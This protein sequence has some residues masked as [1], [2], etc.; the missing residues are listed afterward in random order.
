MEEKSRVGMK[1]EETLRVEVVEMALPGGGLFIGQVLG[2]IPEGEGEER[3]PSGEHYK[4]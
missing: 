2:G 4:G 3:Y 1:A